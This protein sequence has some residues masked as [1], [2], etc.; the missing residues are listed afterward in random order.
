[1]TQEEMT[2]T[3][4]QE[5]LDATNRTLQIAKSRQDPSA[6]EIGII[7]QIITGWES[8]LARAIKQENSKQNDTRRKNY[9]KYVMSSENAVPYEEW[10][11]MAIWDGID[12]DA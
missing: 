10:L 12:V 3:Q 8:A 1:M 2:A 9:E 7:E 5:N 6:F 4:I 11:M